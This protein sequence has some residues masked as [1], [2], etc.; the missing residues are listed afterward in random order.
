MIPCDLKLPYHVENCILKVE[1]DNKN[2]KIL[3]SSMRRFFSSS[4]LEILA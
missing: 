2:V 1:N 4:N 3:T